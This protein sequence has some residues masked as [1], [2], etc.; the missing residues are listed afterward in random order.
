MILAAALVSAPSPRPASRAVAIA[1]ARII[2]AARVRLGVS[3]PH[4]AR[5]RPGLIEFQ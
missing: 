1:H 5:G 4:A 2:S 3:T